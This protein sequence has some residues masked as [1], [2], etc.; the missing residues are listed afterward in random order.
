MSEAEAGS[1]ATD[2]VTRAV[3]QGDKYIL[4]GS[5]QFISYADVAGAFIVLARV[6]NT[7]KPADIGAFIVDRGTKGFEIGKPEINM[8]SEVQCPLYFDDCEVP[9]ENVL[10]EENAFRYLFKVY[11]GV[12][13]GLSAQTLGVAEG[14]Y[15]KCLKYVRERHQFGR[16]ICE[17]QAIQLMLADMKIKIE[18]AKYLMYRACSNADKGI[19]EREEASTAKVLVAESSREI[20]DMAIQIFAGYGYQQD[21]PLE[22]YYRIVRGSS[23][24]GGT[25]QIHKIAIAEE[26]LGRRFNQRPPKA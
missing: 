23:I 18:A 17:F 21:F 20:C 10:L 1:A 12:R 8:S 15:N 11:N 7:G 9:L 14:A 22:W 16:E 24:A 2:L 6:G 25:V 3:K 13:L 5:K 4:N 26:A 19:P